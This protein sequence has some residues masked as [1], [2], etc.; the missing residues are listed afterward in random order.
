[1]KK[2]KT[3][4]NI[5]Y[6]LVAAGSIALV[7]CVKDETYTK[8]GD[9]DGERIYIDNSKSVF[10]VQTAEEKAEENAQ[11]AKLSR[12]LKQNIESTDDDKSVTL[13]LCRLNSKLATY[14]TTVELTLPSDSYQLFTLPAGATQSGA[15]TGTVIYSFE[16]SF[17]E[18]A[19]KTTFDIGFDIAELTANVE[20]NMTATIADDGNT[21]N[22]GASAF[23]FLICHKAQVELPFTDI[24]KVTLT[25]SFFRDIL[26][27]A[28]GSY[29]DCVIQ[30]HNDDL[31]AIN[32]AKETGGEPQFDYVGVRFFIPRLMYQI[33][34]ASIE[35]GETEFT[36]EDLEYFANGD[37]LILTMTPQYEPIEEDAAPNYPHPLQPTVQTTGYPKSSVIGVNSIDGSLFTGGLSE[38]EYVFLATV[39]VNIQDYGETYI[40]K[41][42]DSYNFGT[43]SRALNTY[44]YGISYWAI[45]S[46]NGTLW[47]MPLTITWD[48]N[49]LEP[50]W[51]TYFTVNYNTSVDYV[52]AKGSGTFSSTAFPTTEGGESK[53]QTW[54]QDLYVGYDTATS[55]QVY[56]LPNVYQ[57]VLGEEKDYGLAALVNG[58][59]V[60]V[61]SRQQ[62]GMQWNGNE[63]YA[64]QSENINSSIEFA[65]DGSLKKLTLGVAFV[66]G[67]GNILADYTE[68]Y[69]FNSSASGAEAFFGTYTQAAYKI[70][71]P[72]YGEDGKTELEPQPSPISS[73]VTIS[74]A[75]DS[76]NKPVAGKV[77][78]EGLVD[79]W[80]IS[81]YG[82][83]DGRLVGEYDATSNCI[84]VPAQYLYKPE[85]D[86]GLGFPILP[87]FQPGVGGCSSYKIDEDIYW[88]S[89][90]AAASES[91]ALYLD[92]E[93]NL[94]LG[95]ST[96]DTTGNQT[97]SYAIQ[98]NYLNTQYLEFTY[99]QDLYAAVP[100][101]GPITFTRATASGSS[102]KTQSAV[103]HAAKNYKVVKSSN[104]S[105]AAYEFKEIGKSINPEQLGR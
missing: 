62:L 80:Y 92:E 37:G 6:L 51:D 79:S 22:Y 91:C 10:Y 56:Y 16:V 70:Y 46:P 38:S 35:A 72:Y 59:A 45:N 93:G 33:A 94:T 23:D 3:I 68:T 9:L 44:V 15:G 36:E 75:L 40:V 52:K 77:F 102:V 96:T 41:F 90:I 89:D 2:M 87:Y 83:E 27:Y 103:K 14:T 105:A 66:L 65:E 5:L 99:L 8:G 74:Q 7:G 21:T 11:L 1:M 32:K 42:P 53:P 88:I 47:P 78:I 28:L 85:W 24:G 17:D 71:S 34:A 12:G 20:Y 104:K 48:V 84:I 13:N 26:G 67:N 101:A 58:S 39:P 25:E 61:A 57:T 49:E 100:A 60:T 43:N 69:E 82:L 64:Q 19:D 18:G 81:Q 4:K 54:N 73:T 50:N 98:L 63:I 76:S 30:I 97:D 55:Q 31:E 86:L 29:S 95:F